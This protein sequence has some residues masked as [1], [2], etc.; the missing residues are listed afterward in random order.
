MHQNVVLHPVLFILSE[1]LLGR[2]GGWQ[3]IKTLA[4]VCGKAGDRLHSLLRVSADDARADRNPEGLHQDFEDIFDE[5][6][7][8]I[9]GKKGRKESLTM[10]TS[11]RRIIATP[12]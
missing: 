8:K 5:H 4:I 11:T 2:A 10:T 3:H 6:T 12:F 7:F 9:K 1:F